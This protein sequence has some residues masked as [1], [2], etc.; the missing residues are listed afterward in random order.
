[1]QTPQSPARWGWNAVTALRAQKPVSKSPN[2]ISDKT[3]RCVVCT[4][5]PH[6]AYDCFAL[7]LVPLN[8]GGLSV[9]KDE[10]PSLSHH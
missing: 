8:F 7:A 6:L 10:W 2:N 4:A 5:E 9:K 3:G 1:C